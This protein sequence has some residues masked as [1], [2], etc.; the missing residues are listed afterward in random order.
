[1]AQ[2]SLKRVIGSAIRRAR[3]YLAQMETEANAIQAGE[4]NQNADEAEFAFQRLNPIFKR[5]TAE[6]DCSPRPYYVWGV[7]QGADLGKALGMERISVVEFGVAGGNGLVALERIAERVEQTVGIGVDVYGFDSG[8][9]LPPPV[10]YRD[11]PNLWSSG[12]F[13]M[14]KEK[15]QKRLRRAELVLGL[16]EETVPR[17]IDSKPSPVAFISFDLD[18]YSS[19]MQAFR[20]LEAAAP[21]TILPRIYCYF[22]DIIGF[23]YSDYNGERLAISEFNT[24]HLMR[25]ISPIHGLQHF[26]PEPHEPA[27][28]HEM[29]YMMHAFD[30]PLYNRPDGSVRRVGRAW[31]DLAD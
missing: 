28:W 19:T 2:H 5:L 27:W 1:M 6:P 7:L 21:S 11:C 25:K 23:S 31:T 20:L 12:Y 13:P 18:Y 9:G 30:H 15:L 24:V 29:F 10:D 16:V 22:D 26:L 3:H 8:G 4:Q 14:D 17:F